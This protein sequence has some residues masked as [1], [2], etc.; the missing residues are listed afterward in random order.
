MTNIQIQTLVNEQWNIIHDR[1]AKLRNTDYI[2]V[3]I[4]EGAATKEEYQDKI[5]LRQAWRA[6]INAAQA[7]LERLS[8]IEPEQDIPEIDQ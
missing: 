7:E 2:A 6:D 8:N 1:E 3:K 5:D 4:A